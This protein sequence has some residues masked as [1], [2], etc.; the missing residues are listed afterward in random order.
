MHVGVEGGGDPV[1]E[2]LHERAVARALCGGGVLAGHR[3]G[4]GLAAGPL[5]G[6]GAGDR[7]EREAGVGQ[8]EPQGVHVSDE[9]GV[10][11]RDPVLTGDPGEQRLGLRGAGGGPH[12]EAEGAQVALE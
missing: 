11:E 3:A 1:R 12:V 2:A 6:D 5:G 10:D 8:A 9:P 7:G 4:Q